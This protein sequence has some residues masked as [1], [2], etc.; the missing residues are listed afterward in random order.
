MWAT[1][2]ALKQ[3]VH[4]KLIFRFF[5]FL[6]KRF[7]LDYRPVQ[8]FRKGMAKDQTWTKWT[9]R[10]NYGAYEIYY[11]MHNRTA[12]MCCRCNNVTSFQSVSHKK[13]TQQR[14]NV[15]NI[16]K[17]NQNWVG[18]EFNSPCQTC[19]TWTTKSYLHSWA[20]ITLTHSKS[21]NRQVWLVWIGKNHLLG[22][23]FQTQIIIVS[24]TSH[25]YRGKRGS[26]I[27]VLV[28]LEWFAKVHEETL[29]KVIQGKEIAFLGA[30]SCEML[31][32]VLVS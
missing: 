4:F 22:G 2:R 21:V 26:F 15:P 3:F 25:I 32:L 16:G 19:L 29:G 8:P 18:W 30:C 24:I 6:R 1:H 5:W 27:I 31:G 13:T 17:N 28:F 9:K 14:R 23:S 10:S 11:N 12:T 20:K 7:S